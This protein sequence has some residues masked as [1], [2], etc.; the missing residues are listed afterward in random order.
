[1]TKK[2]V[3]YLIQHSDDYPHIQSAEYRW[4]IPGNKSLMFHDD[5]PEADKNWAITGQILQIEVTPGGI[6]NKN[7]FP[8]GYLP[9]RTF[10]GEIGISNLYTMRVSN[11]LQVLIK[12][13]VPHL[14]LNVNYIRRLLDE[15]FSKDY[16]QEAEFWRHFIDMLPTYSSFM[17]PDIIPVNSQTGEPVPLGALQFTPTASKTSIELWVQDINAIRIKM[18]DNS[19]IFHFE[20]D[21]TEKNTYKMTTHLST[22][23][24]APQNWSV[25]F[26]DRVS[27]Q[28]VTSKEELGEIT[29]EDVLFQAKDEEIEIEDKPSYRN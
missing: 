22:F 8:A 20:K 9:Y 12:L 5:L 3:D 18:F 26:P 28:K 1:M 14:L 10:Y 4:V 6:W 25:G 17:R 16:S 7:N 27:G 24:C 13:A 11:P 15:K 21:Q 2:L 23:T 19:D 29:L